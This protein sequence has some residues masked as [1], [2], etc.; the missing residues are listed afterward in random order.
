MTINLRLTS[1]AATEVKFLNKS[2]LN[3]CKNSKNSLKRRFIRFLWK[4][5]VHR[6][7]Q[8][9]NKKFKK[10]VIDHSIALFCWKKIIFVI[11][12]LIKPRMLKKSIIILILWKYLTEDKL[13]VISKNMASKKMMF[14]LFIIQNYQ[15]KKK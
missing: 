5:S 9:W 3:T 7:F 6:N 15:K 11:A 2:T 1:I 8:I 12:N 4:A 10:I 14:L 13:E